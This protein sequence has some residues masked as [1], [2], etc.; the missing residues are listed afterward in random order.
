MRKR[1]RE[2]ERESYKLPMFAARSIAEEP[3]SPIPVF[4]QSDSH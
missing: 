3:D 2:R 1:E 4:Q